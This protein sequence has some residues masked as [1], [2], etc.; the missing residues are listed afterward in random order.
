MQKEY[1]LN[2]FFTNANLQTQAHFRA[3]EEITIFFCYD[4]LG[5]Q[6]VDFQV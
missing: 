5:K 4:F 6:F 3:K 2:P 1:F